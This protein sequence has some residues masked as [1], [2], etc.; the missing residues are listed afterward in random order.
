M[1]WENARHG[2]RA[3]GDG[4]RIVHPMA[5]VEV[6]VV[7]WLAWGVVAGLLGKVWGVSDLVCGLFG[8]EDSPSGIS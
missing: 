4:A 1:G 6:C 8:S 5:T 2:G 3:A 7:A